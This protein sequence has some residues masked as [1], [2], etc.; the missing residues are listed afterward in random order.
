MSSDRATARVPRAW[1]GDLLFLVEN[2]VLK[3]FRIRYRNM[4]LG[5][6]WSLINPLIMMGVLTFVFSHL[7]HDQTRTAYPL[8]FLCG[9]VPYNFFSGALIS[10]TT[11]IVE[12]S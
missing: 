9:L 4:S 8:F 6:L 10:G 7:I 2:L 12:S 3:D 1:G 11:S 5:I